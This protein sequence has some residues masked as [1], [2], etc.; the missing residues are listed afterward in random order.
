MLT[1]LTVMDNLMLGAYTRS[2]RGADL[3]PTIDKQFTTFSALSRTPVTSTPPTLSGGEQQIACHCPRLLMRP[4][5][6]TIAGRAE[7][8]GLA[9][10]LVREIFSIIKENARPLGSR[11]CW[12]E[13]E[14]QPSP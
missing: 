5:T 11:S 14:R 6:A 8:L 9:P 4:P 12:W 13:A 2:D 1:R 10:L 3:K 7:V